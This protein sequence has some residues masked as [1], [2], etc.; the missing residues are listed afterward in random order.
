M[1]EVVEKETINGE[2]VE[3]KANELLNLNG[4]KLE[5]GFKEL[6][7]MNPKFGIQVA[8]KAVDSIKD[9]NQNCKKIDE[10][11]NESCTAVIKSMSKLIDRQ[12][13]SE[14]ERNKC[15]E[16]MMEVVKVKNEASKRAMQRFWG[17]LGCVVVTVLGAVGIAASAAVNNKSDK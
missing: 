11:L 10:S 3:K 12:D 4:S 1:S 7:E 5:T 6:L 8:I 2:L 13:I 14:A 9:A 16:N 15:V 17:T